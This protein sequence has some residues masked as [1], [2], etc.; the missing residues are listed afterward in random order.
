MAKW[1]NLGTDQCFSTFSSHPFYHANLLFADTVM[2]NQLKLR[3]KYTVK[4]ARLPLC[5]QV[6]VQSSPEVCSLQFSSVWPEYPG[7]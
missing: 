5:R 6:G 2:R 4:D 3:I 7:S 1:R